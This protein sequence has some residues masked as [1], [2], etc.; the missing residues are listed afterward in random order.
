MNQDLAFK[1][2][3]LSV[4]LHF[5][6]RLLY[7][8]FVPI[9][10]LKSGFSM[11]QV[12]LYTLGYVIIIILTSISCVKFLSKKNVIFFNIL[13]IISELFLLFLLLPEKIS[14]LILFGVILFEGFYYGFYYLSYN[15]IFNFY[16][17]SKKT[18]NN[19]GNLQIAMGI[20]SGIAPLIGA[21][22]LGINEFWFYAVSILFL[23]ISIIPL[24][25]IV[26]EDING[27]S[28]EK[29]KIKSI[30]K[31]LFNISLLGS[32]EVSI[33]ILW[34]LY[35]YV[36]G[37]SLLLIGFIP[38]TQTFTNVILTYTIKKRLADIKLR[39][40]IKYLSIVGIIIFSIYRYYLPNY[41]I[42]TN[43]ILGLLFTAFSLGVNSDIY[44]KVKG[45]QT[46]YS[47]MLIDVSSF[48]GWVI[49]VSLTFI[50]GLKNIILA[51]ILIGIIYL[52]T[53]LKK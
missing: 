26:N 52:I 53:N 11:N 49:I 29:V 47:S 30:R 12:L 39:N 45:Y 25:R 6:G 16:N 4:F 51:P 1:Y 48:S 10:L 5:I 50:I 14:I 9:L 42:F 34:A 17:S 18:S 2:F 19:L 3:N 7:R 13:G 44:E 33:F 41:I 24:M 28:Q 21:I 46:Y 23:L 20:A 38:A 32:F 27:K 15:S 22:L 35:V 8:T 37:Y 31:E 40:T 36:E 43:I